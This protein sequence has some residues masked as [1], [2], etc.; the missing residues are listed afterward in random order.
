[1]SESETPKPR[2]TWSSAAKKTF[3][4]ILEANPTMNDA[5]LAGLYQACD[6][7][8]AADAMQ[9]RVNA[10]GVVAEGSQGQP[11]A[12]PLIAEVRHYR[13]E[14]VT[15]L[16]SLGLT[17]QSA[18][19]AAAVAMNAKRWGDRSVAGNVTPIT[20]GVRKSARERYAAEEEPEKAAAAPF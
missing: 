8:A 3:T 15:M 20:Q 19:S 7:L 9:R 16:R 10:D 17:A 13:R 12:H 18:A 1:M 4:D 2:S 5:T 14:A 6:F 11:V